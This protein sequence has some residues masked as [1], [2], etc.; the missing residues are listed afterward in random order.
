MLLLATAG[1]IAEGE[2]QATDAC[3]NSG[4]SLCIRAGAGASTPT[5]DCHQDQDWL[6]RIAHVHWQLCLRWQ[7][8]SVVPAY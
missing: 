3:G 5:V 7:L 6:R 8:V 1:G 4:H 2:E